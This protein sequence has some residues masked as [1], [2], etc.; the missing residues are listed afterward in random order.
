MV[1]QPT[2]APELGSL[3]LTVILSGF[4]TTSDDI[5]AP[6]DTKPPSNQL[7]IKIY[8]GHFTYSSVYS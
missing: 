3:R 2:I 8:D 4:W 1:G 6:V 5:C 7:V